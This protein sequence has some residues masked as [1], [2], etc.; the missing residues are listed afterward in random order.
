[1]IEVLR[2]HYVKLFTTFYFYY[3]QKKKSG[4]KFKYSITGKLC[5]ITPL[6]SLLYVGR[7]A[8]KVNILGKLLPPSDIENVAYRPS[9]RCQVDTI[10]PNTWR[11]QK[12]VKLFIVIF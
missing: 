9:F 1:M 4:W 3:L 8:N 2:S 7:K 12:S 6:S 10:G 5:I 11:E